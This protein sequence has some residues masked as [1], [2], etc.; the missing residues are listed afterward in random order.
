MN[1]TSTMTYDEWA[2]RYGI[3]GEIEPAETHEGWEGDGFHYSVTL[4]GGAS[5]MTVPFSTGTGWDHAPTVA[6]V[7]DSLASDASGFEDSDGFE[8]WAAGLG[9]DTDSRKAEATYRAVEAQTA[10]LR[11]VAGDGFEDLL[12]NTERL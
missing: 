7:L 5:A 12:W 6:D 8:D 10:E 2:E 11:Q 3:T 4:R 1:E 9:Y